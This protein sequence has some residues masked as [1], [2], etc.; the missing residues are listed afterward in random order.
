MIITQKRMHLKFNGHLADVYNDTVKDMKA[1][2]GRNNKVMNLLQEMR[3]HWQE[4]HS[5]LRIPHLF[6][7]VDGVCDEHN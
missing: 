1:E 4:V 3:D 6:T 5:K 2:G 7:V